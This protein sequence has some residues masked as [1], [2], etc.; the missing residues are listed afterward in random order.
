VPILIDSHNP[1]NRP[2]TYF[3]HPLMQTELMVIA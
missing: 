1:N 3:Y 2:D